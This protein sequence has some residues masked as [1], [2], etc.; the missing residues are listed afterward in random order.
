MQLAFMSSVGYFLLQK[1]HTFADKPELVKKVWLD[2]GS[3]T[4]N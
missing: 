2:H 4:A 3:P 1:V